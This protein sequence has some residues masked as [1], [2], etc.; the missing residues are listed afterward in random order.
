MLKLKAR[1]PERLDDALFGLLPRLHNILLDAVNGPLGDRGALGKLG[2]T[3]AQ[4]CP[5]RSDFSS[6]LHEIRHF[7]SR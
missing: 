3:L 6:E 7:A 1:R 4:H 2:L 5:A